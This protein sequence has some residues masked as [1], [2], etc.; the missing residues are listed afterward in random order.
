MVVRGLCEL[1][2]ALCLCMVGLPTPLIEA[3]PCT[4]CWQMDYCRRITMI[5]LRMCVWVGGGGEG[6]RVCVLQHC[7]LS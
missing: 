1:Q 3:S 7:W 2:A 6:G 5:N 4:R